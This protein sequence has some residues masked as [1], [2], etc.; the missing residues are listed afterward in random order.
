MQHAN[1]INE[2]ALLKMRRFEVYSFERSV[3][4]RQQML[5]EGEM[6][7]LLF[8]FYSRG[9]WLKMACMWRKLWNGSHA[10]QEKVAHF[11]TLISDFLLFYFV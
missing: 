1:K 3:R 10:T 6:H 7:I 2:A 9:L 11:L 5:N 4:Q 8:G